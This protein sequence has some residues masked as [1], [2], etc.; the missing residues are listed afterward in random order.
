MQEV[1]GAD[2]HLWTVGVDWIGSPLMAAELQN[3]A[4]AR[5]LLD[6]AAHL[7]TSDQTLDELFA[8]ARYNNRY[9]SRQNYAQQEVQLIVDET[10][11]RKVKTDKDRHRKHDDD[12]NEPN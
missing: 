7:R 6:R 3:L 4:L 10:D 9:N 11:G 5:S 12:L 1:P 8:N 2:L